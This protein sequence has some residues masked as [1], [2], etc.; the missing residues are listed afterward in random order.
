MSGGGVVRRSEVVSLL[1]DG[2]TDG[3]GQI[4]FGSNGPDLFD[5]IADVLLSAGLVKPDLDR[6]PMGDVIAHDR[7][8]D[9]WRYADGYWRSG[10]G[11]GGWSWD[12]VA[13]RGPL[14]Y[15][16]PVPGNRPAV[17]L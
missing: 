15:Y 8:G 16:A 10:Q 5:Q 6:E 2:L 14:R 4:W 11:S 7:L 1:R 17:R 13:E 9:M 3:D 12:H